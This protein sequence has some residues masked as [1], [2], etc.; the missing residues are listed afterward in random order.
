MAVA[1]VCAR[2]GECNVPPWSSSRAGPTCRQGKEG[3][4]APRSPSPHLLQAVHTCCSSGRP[5]KVLAAPG[6][7]WKRVVLLVCHCCL[8]Q[9]GCGTGLLSY[10]HFTKTVVPHRNTLGLLKPHGKPQPCKL[11][12]KQLEAWRRPVPAARCQ[13]AQ[14]SSHGHVVHRFPPRTP[15][16]RACGGRA[17][18]KVPRADQL[19]PGWK[20]ETHWLGGCVP[21]WSG[22]SVPLFQHAFGPEIFWT[23]L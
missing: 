5:G 6:A 20:D 17:E 12:H 19:T 9:R 15:L 7:A 3:C 21:P 8:G 11:G 22:A 13:P 16:P 2:G 18:G 4:P 23:V 10:G 1:V 14:H